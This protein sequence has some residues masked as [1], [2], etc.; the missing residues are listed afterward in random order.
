MPQS[1]KKDFKQIKRVAILI[2]TTTSWSRSVIEG[3]LDYTKKHGPW[4]MHLE[5]QT[6]RNRLVLPPNW[7]GDGII[8]RVS[9]PQIAE[10]LRALNI[11]VVNISSIE[12]EG[13]D[14]PRVITS[15]ISIAKLA[16]E[17]FRERGFRNFAYLGDLS[18]PFVTKEFEAY[19]AVL[20]DV[21]HRPDVY[22][23]SRN[24]S[25]T[26]WLHQLMK[27]TGVLCW[28]PS[29]GHQLIDACNLA[30]INVPND[31]AVLGGN[32]DKLL[33]EASYPPQAGILLDSQQ[34]GRTSAHI[35][36]QMIQGKKLEQRF[37]QLEPLRVVDKLSIDTFAIED[38]RMRK[39]MLFLNKHAFECISVEDILRA[40][41]MARR[42]L[43]RKFRATFGVSIIEH[44]R[45]IRINRARELLVS[46]EAPITE[47]AELCGLSSY[48]YLNRIFKNATGLSP[49]QYRARSSLNQK[50]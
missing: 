36:D 16:Y 20:A 37:Y 6:Q 45:Q 22:D 33:S 27:P 8:A 4:H 9:T 26:T 15:P 42:S 2:D 29:L 19:K 18:L 39:V 21:G 43:E 5:A 12:L 25:L 48:N 40:N 44:L 14:F 34:I 46:T 1:K 35:L 10:Q 31:I 28:G 17:T 7:K 32:F 47:I 24:Q 13:F 3:I 38:P 23:L 11:P 49:S 50:S 41:P 30:E